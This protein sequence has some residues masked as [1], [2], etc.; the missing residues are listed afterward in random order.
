M[1]YIVGV[2]VLK[3][4]KRLPQDPLERVFSIKLF[5]SAHGFDQGRDR[6]VHQLNE[7]PQNTT[8]VVVGVN[9]VQAEAVLA[10]AHAHQSNLVIHQLSV[11]I[12]TWRAELQ[13]E[14]L[15]VRLSLNF[16]YF[17]EAA[18]SQLLLTVDVVEG[19]RVL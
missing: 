8:I 6:P 4:A 14:L 16:E 13:R 2:E 18:N 10:R 19:R 9:H 17:C 15:L 11:F 1:H 5:S 7:N 3:A 12:V